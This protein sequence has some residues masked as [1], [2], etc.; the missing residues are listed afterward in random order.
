MPG[1]DRTGPLG[2]GAMTGGCFGYCDIGRGQ[3]YGLRGVKEARSAFE[4]SCFITHAQSA[5]SILPSIFWPLPAP[6]PIIR[7]SVSFC[8]PGFLLLTFWPYRLS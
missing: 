5:L 3:G 8:L 1:F 7:K 2:Q 6:H 4:Y